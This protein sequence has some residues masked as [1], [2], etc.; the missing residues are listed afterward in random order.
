MSLVHN[1]RVKLTAAYL[2]TG[3]GACFAAG[4]VAPLAALA[5]GYGTVQSNVSALTFWVGIATFVANA[6]CRSSLRAQGTQAV[7]S[8]E[9][10]AVIIVPVIAA[11]FGWGVALWARYAAKRDREADH[12]A[13]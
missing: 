12:T 11:A 2:N 3:A 6:E 8:F 10:F 4:V 13:R 9:I 5:F 1:E 7:T